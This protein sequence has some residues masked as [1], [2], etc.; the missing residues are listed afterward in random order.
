MKKMIQMRGMK[1]MEMARRAKRKA[2][3][4]VRMKARMLR[5]EVMCLAAPIIQLR[6]M[7]LI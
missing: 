2:M 1:K 7:K 5:R 4:K 3:K 6:D